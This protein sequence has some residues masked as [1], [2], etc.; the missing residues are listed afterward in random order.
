MSAKTG[1]ELQEVLKQAS[2]SV[3]EKAKL[4]GAPLYYM[5]NG[6]RIR[7][8]ADGKKVALII[9]ADGKTLEFPVELDT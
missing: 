1:Q 8:D 7:E 4:S 2:K 5:H 9:D 3:R 6:N